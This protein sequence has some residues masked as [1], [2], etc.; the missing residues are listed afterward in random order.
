MRAPLSSQDV[1]L[2]LAQSRTFAHLFQ[3][4]LE[5]D[6]E[7]Q[8]V[9]RRMSAIIVDPEVDDDDSAMALAT[10]HEALRPSRSE[11]DG[12]LGVD[13]EWEERMSATE[14]ASQP[15]AAAGD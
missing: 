6:P 15:A 11:R 7:I 2:V 10:L 9:I 12:L 5:C 14:D 1:D 4:Y 8:A 3:E 13:L